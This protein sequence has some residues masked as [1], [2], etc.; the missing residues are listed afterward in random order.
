VNLDQ[1]IQSIL[2]RVASEITHAVRADV[3]SQIERALGNGAAPARRGRRP[4]AAKPA[5][6][7][8]APGKRGR[9][10][11]DEKSLATV[12]QYVTRHPG[13]R[14]EEIQ[15]AAGVPAA[16]AKKALVKLREAGRVKMKGVKRAATYAAA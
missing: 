1:Q 3:A 12:L 8:K 16:L 7:P 13:K 11:I 5:A 14:S 10:G 6:A 4:K 2:S 15:K 9:R